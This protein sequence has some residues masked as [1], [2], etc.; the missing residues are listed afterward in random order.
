MQTFRR[1]RHQRCSDIRN[2]Q[3]PL[4][5]DIHDVQTS[6]FPS[7]APRHQVSTIHR[8]LRGTDILKVQPQCTSIHDVQTSAMYRYSSCHPRCTDLYEVQTSSITATIHKHLRCT[9]FHDAQTSTYR[10]PP[11]PDIMNWL[12]HLYSFNLS[13][14]FAQVSSEMCSSP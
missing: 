12:S 5:S 7:T 13:P 2:V 3:H 8:P 14:S 11:C 9:A 4:D 6:T 10:H 1:Y